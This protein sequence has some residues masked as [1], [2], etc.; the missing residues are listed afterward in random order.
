[1]GPLTSRETTEYNI[2]LHFATRALRHAR[3]LCATCAL[4]YARAQVNLH[5]LDSVV[6][7]ASSMGDRL[8]PVANTLIPAV[9]KNL[10]SSNQQVR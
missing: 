8:E 1:M 5:A 4:R 10:A 6:R 3:T 9:C 2:T 7:V